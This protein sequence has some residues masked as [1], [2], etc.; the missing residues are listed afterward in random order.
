MERDDAVDKKQGKTSNKA[1]K[2][3]ADTEASKSKKLKKEEKALATKTDSDD[4]ELRHALILQGRDATKKNAAINGTYMLLPEG[5]AGAKAYKSARSTDSKCLYYDPK[6]G[7]RWKISESLGGAAY[8]AHLPDSSGKG[9]PLDAEKQQ[10]YI[11]EGKAAGGYVLD[12]A[13]QCVPHPSANLIKQ[14]EPNG[15]TV[16]E[17]QQSSKSDESNSSES[18]SSEEAAGDKPAEPKVEDLAPS[19]K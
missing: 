19:N 6:K 17:S 5:H 18:S 3:A 11:F 1:A 8:F 2:V 7:G 12:P 4:A 9:T 15:K 10:W 14:Q 13:V 16:G